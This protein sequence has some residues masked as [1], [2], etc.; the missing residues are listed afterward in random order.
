ME[1]K[2]LNLLK[3]ELD[4]RKSRNPN[5]SLRSFA[6]SLDVSP[7][8]LSEI[9]SGQRMSLKMANKIATKLK[10]NEKTK[11]EF[12]ESIHHQKLIFNESKT[13][14]SPVVFTLNLSANDLKI[15]L[16]KIEGR[17]E[18]TSHNKKTSTLKISLH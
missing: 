12:T 3:K 11:A 2:A 1:V 8:R 17:I 14:S 18:E 15:L 9:L 10:L 5:Y 13:A 7:S 6:R 4:S 16:S